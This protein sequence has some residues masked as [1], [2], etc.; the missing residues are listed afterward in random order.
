MQILPAL[1]N[2]PTQTLT[3]KPP[4]TTTY[5]EETFKIM[6]KYEYEL[7]GLVVSYRLHDSTGGMM[8][9]ALNKDH[10]NVADYCVVWGQSADP[11]ILREFD[12]SNGQ[13]SC[14]FGTNNQAAWEAFEP[15]QLSNNHLLAI[16]E[17]VRDTIDEIRIGDQIHLKGWLAHYQNP[18]GFERGTS[19][20]RH[21]TG[22]GACETILVDQIEILSNMTNLWR[23][24]MWLAV[25]LLVLTLYVYIKAPYEPHKR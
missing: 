4:F 19:I 12:F 25:S 9:H 14:Q 21:D 11:E 22:D 16:D 23:K 5:N 6:P 2:D 8:I 7:Y 18:M 13:F 17:W 10:L 24:L 1:N 20:T 15:H 3:T